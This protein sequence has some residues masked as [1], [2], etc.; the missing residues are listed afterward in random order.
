AS[1]STSRGS[2]FASAPK[3]STACVDTELRILVERASVLN[4]VA[5]RYPAPVRASLA[6]G[7]GQTASGRDSECRLRVRD[8]GVVRRLLVLSA[9]LPPVRSF[10]LLHLILQVFL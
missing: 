1:D 7:D 2:F 8:P 3:G 5:R 10:E 4:R 9:D 6:P